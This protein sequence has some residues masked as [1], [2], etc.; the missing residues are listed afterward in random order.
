MNL[1]EQRIWDYLDGT[2][3]LQER[4]LTE[5]LIK[6]DPV[7]QQVY[8]ECKSFNSLVSAA[9]QDEPTMGFTRN[10]ME[11][12]NLEPVHSSLKSLID[13]RIVFGIAA[14]FL[15]TITALLG[16][17]FYQ[18]DWSQ[19]ISSGMQNYQIP[20]ID[21]SK[22]LNTTLINIFFFADIIAGLYLFDGFLRKRIRSKN[23]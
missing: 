5:R 11:R 8:Q 10:V 21:I 15:F 17:L 4:E 14:F 19:H 9:D 7:Y 3:T 12:I 16:V 23:I 6:T 20:E 1:I 18:I 13:K 2:G 22:Y